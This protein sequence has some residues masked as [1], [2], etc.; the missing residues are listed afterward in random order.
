LTTTLALLACLGAALAFRAEAATAPPAATASSVRTV[1]PPP[2]IVDPVKVKCVKLSYGGRTCGQ[3][4]DDKWKG[5][6]WADP[7]RWEVVDVRIFAETKL[8]VPSDEYK[9]FS[10]EGIFTVKGTP[11]T[12]G[13]VKLPARRGGSPVS[14]AMIKP[15][16]QEMQSIGEWVT[17][18]GSYGCGLKAKPGQLS[19]AFVGAFAAKPDKGTI[20]V[21]WTVS[22]AA[23]SCEGGSAV[24]APS[25]E[26]LPLEAMSVTYRAARFRDAELLKLPVNIDWE[27]V[28]S[29]DGARL[30]LDVSGRVILRRVHHRL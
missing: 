21:Q 26:A 3:R 2:R 25:F 20:S 29:Y 12:K 5:G 15:V 30:L 11:A 10:G 8:E 9:E 18:D 6:W 19:N 23:F 1:S 16:K 13:T 14:V 22:T 27:G 4:L 24:E 7:T 17:K 28:Q